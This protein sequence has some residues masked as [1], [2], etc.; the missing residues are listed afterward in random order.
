M[1][2]PA[3]ELRRIDPARNM[4]RF[5]RLDMQ[6]DLFGGV[7][8]LR[9][10]GRRRIF[11]KEHAKSKAP[12]FQWV[13]LLVRKLNRRRTANKVSENGAL[14]WLLGRFDCRTGSRTPLACSFGK[15]L[16]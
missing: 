14:Q 1:I 8:L 16:S 5:Y 13:L 4:R 9:Q 7:L 10:W 15:I 6:P 3:L 2:A 11:P 12:K